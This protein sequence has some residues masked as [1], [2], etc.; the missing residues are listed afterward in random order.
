[1]LFHS[2]SVIVIVSNNFSL[3]YLAMNYRERQKVN[4]TAYRYRFVYVLAAQRANNLIK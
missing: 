1:L 3:S 2:D 4:Q